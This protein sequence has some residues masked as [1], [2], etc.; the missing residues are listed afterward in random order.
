[1]SSIPQSK[2][3]DEKTGWRTRSHLCAASKEFPSPQK[4]NPA[5]GCQAGKRFPSAL[6]EWT[7]SCGCPNNRQ[8]SNQHWWERRTPPLHADWRTNPP[9]RQD[10]SKHLWPKQR[11]TQCHKT[12]SSTVS[13]RVAPAEQSREVS[14][15]PPP[16]QEKAGHP[17]KQITG[18][19]LHVVSHMWSWL[20]I[21]R[22]LCLI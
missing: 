21:F 18:T 3:T 12:H 8:S 16:F 9:R 10:G 2:D 17:N 19:A 4:T 1:M 15:T 22:F 20:W 7:S 6:S 5:L 13:H 11:S 14:V